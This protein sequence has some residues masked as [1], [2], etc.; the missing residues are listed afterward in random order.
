MFRPQSSSRPRLHRPPSDFRPP[1]CSRFPARPFG[2]HCRAGC[3]RSAR[4]RI[5]RSRFR[6]GPVLHP[7]PVDISFVDPTRCAEWDREIEGHSGA[8]IFHSAAWAEVIRQTY[9]HVPR[10]L[11]LRETEQPRLL[12]PIFEVS[13]WLTQRR[14]V[15]LPFSD[16]CEPLH[17]DH[18]TLTLALE[19]LTAEAKTRGWRYVEFRGPCRLANS[20]T[21]SVSY[22]GHALDL[23]PGREALNRSLSS[24]A[25]RSLRKAERSGLQVDISNRWQ[26][27]VEFCRLHARTRRRQGLPPQPMAF[28]RHLHQEIIARDLGFVS[29]VRHEG[30]PVAAAVF[31]RRGE[32]AI[33]KFGASDERYQEFR[34]N[35]LVMWTAI[36]T[37]AA[38]GVE[39]LDFGRTSLSQD[40]LRRFKRS[41]GAREYPINYFRLDPQS[42]Q[43][44][45]S[46]DKSSG[47]QGALFARSPLLL[48]RL[49][50]RLIYPHLD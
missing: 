22:H 30:R 24:S 9:G 14:G 21:P 42:G 20:A 39:T 15:C 5:P 50:G 26:D 7:P 19:A 40:G 11:R 13:S 6:S 46:R 45:T 18:A 47:L 27:V 43:W 29:I 38:Q 17:F 48:N 25:R 34:G 3:R 31:L 49:A 8:G 10:Y 2:L 28:F 44:L 16:T 35:H 33:Y 32:K 37:L 1:R 41:W 23:R 12:L 4:L 36:E